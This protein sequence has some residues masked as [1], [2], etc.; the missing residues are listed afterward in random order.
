ML[1]VLHLSGGEGPVAEILTLHEDG[2]L[3][4]RHPARESTRINCATIHPERVAAIRALLRS[5]DVRRFGEALAKEGRPCCDQELAL[6]KYGGLEFWV[7]NEDAPDAIGELFSVLDS[8][9]IEGFGRAYLLRLA[10]PGLTAL[11][12]LAK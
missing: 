5:P 8:V 4:L 10:S 11:P 6:V 1:E 9:F 7:A 3:G 12:R 2:R